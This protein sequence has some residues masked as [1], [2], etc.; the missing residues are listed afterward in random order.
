MNLQ[1][2]KSHILNAVE[3]D[4][5]PNV[6]FK[7][8]GN[9][10]A[11]LL[12]NLPMGEI[13]NQPGATDLE[14]VTAWFDT[15]DESDTDSL[16]GVISTVASSFEEKITDGITS[17]K[18]LH[19]TVASLESG[20]TEEY[21]KRVASNPRLAKAVSSEGID[22]SLP[23]YDFS[24]LASVGDSA[25]VINGVEEA[26]I[27]SGD[28]APGYKFRVAT[29]RYLPRA[30][31]GVTT[32]KVIVNEES[33][34]SIS[35]TLVG[36]GYSADNVKN[37]ITHVTL[38]TGLL[39]LV[40]KTKMMVTDQPSTDKAVNWCMSI[41]NEFG[42]CLTDVESTVI[43]EG[44]DADKIDN[45]VKIMSAILD[46][47]AYFVYHHRMYSFNNTVLF[48]NGE[49]NPDVA[50]KALAAD[51][52]DEDIVKHRAALNSNLAIPKLGLTIDK[53]VANK[54]RVEKI[55]TEASTEDAKYVEV[56]QREIMVKTISKTLSAHVKDYNN[57]D[58]YDN[59]SFAANKMAINKT[60]V[61]DL[62]YSIL[63]NVMHSG[64]IV[65]ELYQ[66]LGDEYSNILSNNNTVSQ[67]LVD[68]S[69]VKVYAE[70]ITQFISKHF[71][72]FE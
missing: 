2:I 18:E 21:N 32:S 45:N 57:N 53:I 39:A 33:K 70:I 69:T 67:D 63:I 65:E 61:H 44:F 19:A 71:V 20:I 27:D 14:R 55:Y 42:P 15:F 12:K 56:K 38:G 22:F 10:Y 9:L 47:C 51:I 46:L 40:E 4:A 41:V 34:Q 35:D 11:A 16:M 52:T 5:L 23:T 62:L 26:T 36:K 29:S 8:G 60:P 3:A 50:K 64:T 54:E 25:S 30:L 17:L 1:F 58:M 48:S 6:S 72:D 68:E 49:K 43:A 31:A 13:D 28:L 37:V 24:A 59:I 7:P 66:K